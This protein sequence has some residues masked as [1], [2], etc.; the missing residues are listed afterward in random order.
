M[1][2]TASR[3]ER[4]YL[5]RLSTTTLPLSTGQFLKMASG[6]YLVQTSDGKNILIDSGLPPE[7][8]PPPGTPAG[9]PEKNVLEH[10]AALGLQPDQIDFLI[11]T[12]FDVDHAGY[13]DF[14]AQAEFLVQRKHYELA[15]SGQARY[16]PA[17]PHWNHPALRYRLLDGDTE[18]LPG[19][20]LIESSGH[21]L[22]HQSVLVRLPQSGPVL[23]AIDAVMFERQFTPERKP[24][25]VDEDATQLLASTQKLLELVERERIELVVFGHDGEQW[26]TLK[27][28]PAFYA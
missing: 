16:A 27:R 3:P 8:T 22:G 19:L 25:P 14:F 9:Q 6:C 1:T 18:L 5:L 4:L 7:Y 26:E 2:Q 23:L 24:S 15:C 21:A 10:L 12:H 11:C 20:T 28:A 17:R 13:H